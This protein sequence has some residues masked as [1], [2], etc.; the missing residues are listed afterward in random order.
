MATNYLPTREADFLDW[1][2]SF[3]RTLAVDP[4]LFGTN[5]NAVDAYEE[6]LNRFAASYSK[7][8]DPNTRTRPMIERKDQDKKTLVRST[9]SMVRQ[10]QA[11]PETTDEQRRQL[12]ITV[13]DRKP[14]PHGPPTEMPATTLVS[15]VRHTIEMQIRREDGGRGRPTGTNG[16]NVYYAV[17][18]TVPTSQIGWTHAGQATRMNTQITLPEST[19]A[20]ATVWIACCWYNGRGENGP[21]SVAI[22]TNLPGGQSRLAA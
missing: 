8:T 20:G 5:A 11:R 17:S 9:Q 19:P 13:P 1:C 6:D 22:A 7:A 12:K 10:I 16:A 2:Q 14:T 21:L 4:V 18:P 15:A 3:H